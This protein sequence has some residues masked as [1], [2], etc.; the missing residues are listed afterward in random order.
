M[1]DLVR[2]DHQLRWAVER[3]GAEA[4]E[5]AELDLLDEL[6]RSDTHVLRFAGSARAEAV[7]L[8]GGHGPDPRIRLGLSKN[9]HDGQLRVAAE[10]SVQRWRALAEHPAT[11]GRDRVA[12][13]VL[14]RSAEGLLTAVRSR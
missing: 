1:A 5:I 7:R 10:Q 4:H 14:V 9:A 11:G 12:C 13:E 8:L 3:I 6:E 2:G